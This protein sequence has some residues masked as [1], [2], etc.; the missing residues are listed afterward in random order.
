MAEPMIGMLMCV[1]HTA[2]MGEDDRGG[3]PITCRYN[4]LIVPAFKYTYLQG[5]SSKET[6]P[7]ISNGLETSHLCSTVCMYLKLCT[8]YA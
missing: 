7:G 1:L 6:F 4:H 2:K 5:K 3:P 8:T